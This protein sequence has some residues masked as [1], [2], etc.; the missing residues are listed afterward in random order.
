[1]VA[2]HI[3]PNRS[4]HFIVPVAS[5]SEREKVRVIGSSSD[6]VESKT[7]VPLMSPLAGEQCSPKGERTA[8]EP[9]HGGALIRTNY[10][11]QRGGMR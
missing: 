5:S 9:S 1:M 2:D 11:V 3:A 4:P 10:G 8:I 7:V 6:P